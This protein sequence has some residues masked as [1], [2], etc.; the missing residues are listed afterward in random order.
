MA[1]VCLATLVNL[2]LKFTLLLRGIVLLSKLALIVGALYSL[3]LALTYLRIFF[4]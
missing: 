2:V 4:L 1:S 3:L